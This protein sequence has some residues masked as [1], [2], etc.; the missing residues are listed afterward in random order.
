MADRQPAVV[1]SDDCAQHRSKSAPKR[2]FNSD[3]VVTSISEQIE[4]CPV[5]VDCCRERELESG[6]KR[7]KLSAGKSEISAKNQQQEESQSQPS[8]ASLANDKKRLRQENSIDVYYSEMPLNVPFHVKDGIRY[9]SPYWTTYRT[10]AKGRW[11]GRKMVEVFRKE[12]LSQNANYAM[13]ACKL[14]R[15]FVNGQQVLDPE[16]RFKPNDAIVHVGHRH[17][18][19]I[20]DRKIRILENS[21]D[22]LVVDKPPSMPV[23]ACGQYRLHTVMGL[24]YTQYNIAG[25]RVLHRLD[26]TTSGVLIF[27]K[28]YETDSEFKE[29]LKAGEW[30]KEYVCKVDGVFPGE[31]EVLCD[32]PLGT[33]V[34]SMGIQ[35]VREEGGK[36]ARTRFRRLWTDGKR[37]SVLKCILETGRTHQIRVHLQYLGGFQLCKDISDAHRYSLWHETVHPD[38]EQRMERL[39]NGEVEPEPDNLKMDGRPDYDPICLGCNVTKRRPSESHFM[40]HLHCLKYETEKWSF[41]TDLPDWAVEPACERIPQEAYG[42]T[43]IG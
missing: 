16:Y 34:I 28:N 19:P 33:L 8:C 39:A 4:R 10:R 9:L 22:L 11:I 7:A 27:A 32:E 25:L 5:A 14:G 26:R 24:L 6:T 21:A 18:H 36:P 17:E 23:H 1:N 41:S 43:V 31:D 29:T 40:L 20:L 13:V 38:Y 2:V 30:H 15:L 3:D 42:N 12:F 35:C 37:F